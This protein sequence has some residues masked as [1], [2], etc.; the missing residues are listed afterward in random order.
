MIDGILAEV[1]V[2]DKFLAE[3]IKDGIES[4]MKEGP[5]SGTL[6]PDWTA[7]AKLIEIAAKIKRLYKTDNIILIQNAFQKVDT[8]KDTWY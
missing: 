5:K 4:A 2:T 3:M 1:G 7:R 8:S 6:I